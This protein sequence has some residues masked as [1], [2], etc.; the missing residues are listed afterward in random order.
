VP[1]ALSHAPH[2]PPPPVERV[3]NGRS[4]S[5]PAFLLAL[6]I[7]VGMH[8]GVLMLFHFTVAPPAT[9][10]GAPATPHV[11]YNDVAANPALQTLMASV[12][13]SPEQIYLSTEKSFSSQALPH[14]EAPSNLV[15]KPFD[16]KPTPAEVDFH[17]P[18]PP[19]ATTTGPGDA[20]KPNSWDLLNSFGQTATPSNK[21]P[22]R[23]AFVRITRLDTM[24]PSNAAPFEFTLPPEMAP[25]AGNTGWQPVSFI[26]QF[27]AAG[28]ASEP[29][30]D[31]GFDTMSQ[32]NSPNDPQ[33]NEFLRSKLR[34]W[35]T[36]NPPLPPGQYEAVVGP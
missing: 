32:S 22:A 7:G 8:L 17:Q 14:T 24:G 2:L 1:D 35:F 34:Q 25:P 23:G 5:P 19:V 16:V 33:V 21:L 26:L 30:L 31:L 28:L 15:F 20:L 29:V 12:Q 36:T 27:D 3:R 6:L 9:V 11:H 18:T 13:F 4:S 10:A